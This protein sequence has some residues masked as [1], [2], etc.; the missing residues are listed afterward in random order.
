MFHKIL[1][2]KPKNKKI[3]LKKD[4]LIAVPPLFWKNPALITI[5]SLASML[6][7]VSAMLLHGDIHE[8]ICKLAPTVYS[9]KN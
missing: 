6:T 1:F 9:L 5:T 4:E 7:Q 8:L 2:S 3:V